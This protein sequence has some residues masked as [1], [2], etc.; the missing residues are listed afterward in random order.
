[1]GGLPVT[2]SPLPPRRRLADWL[3][4]YLAYSSYTEAPKRMRLWAGVSAIAGALRRK[5]WIDQVYFQWY[6]NFYVI[7]VAP[8]GVVSKTTTAGV[9]ISLLRK[10]PGI[11]FG[12]DIVTWPSLV[13]KFAEA[14]EM[15]E[16]TDPETGE[17][18]WRPMSAMTLE[19]GEFG[20]LLD[21]QDRAMVDLLVTLWDGKQGDLSKSTK[22][23][24]SDSIENPWINLIACT[25]PSWIAG[26]FP[27]YMIGGGFTSRCVFVYADKKAQEVAYPARR[28]PRDLAAQAEALVA[29]L[30]VI[31]HLVGEYRLTDEAYAW[32]EQWYHRHNT[33]PNAALADDRFGGYLARKQTHIHKL[34]MVLSASAGDSLTITLEHLQIADAL[35]T[36][37]EPDMTMVFSR[38]GRSETS[39]NVERLLT[40]IQAKGQV[41]WA[42]AY[43][44]VHQY[45]PGLRNYEDIVS[46][47]VRAGQISLVQSGPKVYLRPGPAAQPEAKPAE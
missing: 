40:F 31:S 20:N 13:E 28:V 19:S 22:H 12:P 37:L 6:P 29:D 7:F 27:E 17:L 33:T 46:G 43:N 8:P 14:T 35:I 2:E 5:V 47:M 25:T 42:V 1:M 24:G 18:I 30:E 3:T 4:A 26:N 41:E 23:S 36:D 44:H 11:K 15:F 9:A 34:A 21:P 32:G 39:F 16:Y 38:I 45:F 10:V